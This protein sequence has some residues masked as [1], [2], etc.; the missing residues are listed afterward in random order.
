[1]RG[2]PRVSIGLPVF[3]AELYLE[4]SLEAVLG[5]TFRDFELIISSNA[6]TDGTDDIC[7][8]Y[9]ERDE[10]IRFIRQPSNIGAVPNHNLVLDQATAPLFKW[11]SG[12]DLY[13]RDLIERCVALLDAEPELVL[14]HSWT[15][16]INGDGEL[17]QA[18]PYPLATERPEP[19]A[20]LRSLLFAGDEM[21]GAIRADDFYG[22][23][24][25]DVLRKM[26]RLG[27]FYHSDQTYT[28]NLA[29]HGPFGII[30]EWLYFRRHHTGRALE[31]N[32]TVRSWCSNLD[33]RRGDRLRHPT[34]RLIGEYGW[35]NIALIG[36]SPIRLSDKVRCY[37]VMG[38]WMVSRVARRLSGRHDEHQGRPATPLIEPPV[39]VAELVAGQ[40]DAS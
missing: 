4:Q 26:K 5:Q 16:A 18:L 25:T 33:P 14:A 29:L 28:A 37:R 10:R 13:A 11:V 17:I 2:H 19:E 22:V 8:R 20:R 21:P 35:E 27:S 15:A 7:R 32:P 36:R 6:S 1:M 30:P 23:I 12:D 38:Q 9:A 40:H 39:S 31:A 3:N 24:R 34:V